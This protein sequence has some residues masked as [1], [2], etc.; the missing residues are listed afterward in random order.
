MS[1]ALNLPATE[2][3]TKSSTTVPSVPEPALLE[4]QF[5]RQ[6][7][8]DN[9]YRSAIGLIETGRGSQAMVILEPLLLDNPAN[10]AARLLL[11]GLLIENNRLNEARW[12]LQAG[13]EIEPLHLEM[14]MMLA[15]LQVSYGNVEEAIRTLQK[16]AAVSNGQAGYLSFLA[17]LLQRESRYRVSAEHYAQALRIEPQNGLWW[18]GYGI[19]LQAD[20]QRE[21]A[22]EAFRLARDSPGLSVQL[23]AFV[24]QSISQIL[25]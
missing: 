11:A 12:R 24:D 8:A 4:K 16:V 9:A 20:N 18:M 19:A 1:T 17:A 3:R 21:A 15:R 23:R 22:L 2:L 13:L 6:Q 10:S 5:T 25:R 7:R 14:S